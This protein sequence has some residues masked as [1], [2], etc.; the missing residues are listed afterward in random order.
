MASNAPAVPV[1][2]A[3][4]APVSHKGFHYAWIVAGAA[5]VVG[6]INAAFMWAFTLVLVPISNQFGWTSGQISVA[7]TLQYLI[8][9]FGSVFGGW[10]VDRIGARIMLVV[11]SLVLIASMALTST[12]SELWQLYLYFGILLGVSRSA[13]IA[14]LHT[15]VGLW[16]RKR[17]GLAMGLVSAALGVGPLLFVPVMQRAIEQIGWQ[18]ALLWIGLVSGIVMTLASLLIRNKPADLKV[19]PYGSTGTFDAPTRPPV[20]RGRYY[21]GS[22]AGGFMQHARRTQPFYLLIGIH[23]LGCVGHAV[24]LAHARPMITQREQSPE[25]AALTIALISGL[26]VLGYFIFSIFADKQDG[27]SSLVAAFLFQAVGISIMT[28]AQQDWQFYLFALFFGLGMGGEMVVFPIINRQYYGSAPVGTLYGMQ[29]FG[30]GIGMGLGAL[31]GGL[32]FD[33]SGNYITS[34]LFAAGATL[35]GIALILCLARP[36]TRAVRARRQA[37]PPEAVIPPA[38]DAAALQAT[39]A[40]TAPGLPVTAPAPVVVAQPTMT[41]A[42]PVAPL[43][44]AVIGDAAITADPADREM[45]RLIPGAASGSRDRRLEADPAV[46]EMPPVIQQDWAEWVARR[47]S[48]EAALARDLADWSGRT[49]D[50]ELAEVLDIAAARSR[51]RAFRLRRSGWS[52]DVPARTPLVADTRAFDAADVDRIERVVA[53]LGAELAVSV[54]VP[55][56]AEAVLWDQIR[57]ST[58]ETLE[59]IGEQLQRLAPAAAPLAVRLMEAGPAHWLEESGVFWKRLTGPEAAGTAILWVCQWPGSLTLWQPGSAR[60]LLPLEGQGRAAGPA[61]APLALDVSRPVEV[62][63]DAPAEVDA[64][65]DLP[66]TYLVIADRPVE[67]VIRPAA[68]READLVPA[69]AQERPAPVATDGLG[70]D[71]DR[72]T[73]VVR[74]VEVSIGG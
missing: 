36:V 1:A 53:A 12:V 13:F 34:L 63:A 61:S 7:Y 56:P 16:F 40:A 5:F 72:K 37:D 6:A 33:Q 52:P 30:A 49:D 58:H 43:A 11:G 64:G 62:G 48:F 25:F 10:L 69:N 3:P 68:R 15:V 27:R 66:L 24:L 17:L 20:Q 55:G 74:P 23:F 31:G 2:T 8:F 51:D 59:L 70:P 38:A 45:P 50:G 14:P 67:P 60:V 9:A 18:Q 39:I 41:A 65:G 19:L 73:V 57:T 32:L 29:M 71:L 4:G 22:Q 28:I 54:D 47:R 26:S 44:A 35:I 46:R 42:A 21:D